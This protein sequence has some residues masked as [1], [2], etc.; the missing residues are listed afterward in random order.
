MKGRQRWEKKHG[1]KSKEGRRK[2][3]NIHV[4][5]GRCSPSIPL[6]ADETD[7]TMNFFK[8]FQLKASAN[9]ATSYAFNPN[10]AWDVDPAVGSGNTIGLATWSALYAYYR[11]YSFEYDIEF[12]NQDATASKVSVTNTNT[13][14][15]VG[16]G[17][18]ILALAVGNPYCKSRIIANSAGGPCVTRFFGKIDFRRLLGGTDVDTGD[19]WRGLTGSSSPSDLFWLCIGIDSTPNNLTNGCIVSVVIRMNMR[20]Y[21]RNPI[22]S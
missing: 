14:P 3:V 9:T 21:D 1:T 19:N 7:I 11:V 15:T 10:A 20:L 13:S 22:N 16:A 8:L 12:S 4:T 2:R 6:T 17:N 18:S 5:E